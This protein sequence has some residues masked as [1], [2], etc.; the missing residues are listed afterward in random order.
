MSLFKTQ[1]VK[2][3][4]SKKNGFKTNLKKSEKLF[5]AAHGA[6]IGRSSNSRV[7]IRFEFQ[8]VNPN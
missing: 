4:A 7:S 2:L 6:Y 1:Q 5:G 3:A 8:A